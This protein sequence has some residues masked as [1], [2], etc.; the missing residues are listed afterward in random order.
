MKSFAS[1]TDPHRATRPS[2][3]HVP[4]QPGETRD[5]ALVRMAR[6]CR[7]R[8][9]RVIGQDVTGAF[10]VT[11]PLSPQ[12]PVRTTRRWCECLGFQRNGHCTHQAVLLD[13]LGELCDDAA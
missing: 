6:N 7:T 8:S 5:Q 12:I 4:G 9:F 2:P 10:L 11:S 13:T 1:S 3:V